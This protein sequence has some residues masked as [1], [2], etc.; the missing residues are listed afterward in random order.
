MAT[1]KAAELRRLVKQGRAMPV[2]GQDRP[3]R[4]P[5]RGA[6]DLDNAIRAIGRVAGGEDE[7][8]KVRRYVAKRARALGLTAH[9]PASW[10]S[11][12]HLKT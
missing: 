2:P 8:A 6:D 10:R 1:P 12:G 4:F 3:G 9:I 7:R 11:D 5:I